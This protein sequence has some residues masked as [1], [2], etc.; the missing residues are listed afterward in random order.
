MP[1]N[2]APGVEVEETSFRP[3]P[4][5]G[6]STTTTGF[7]GPTRYGPIESQS[8][9][10]TSLSAFEAVYGNGL[11]LQY[12]GATVPHYLWHAARA[13]FENGGTRLYIARLFHPLIGTYPPSNWSTATQTTPGLYDDGHARLSIGSDDQPDN[14]LTLRARFPGAAGNLRVRL[15]VHRGPNLLSGTSSTPTLK[16]LSHHAVVWIG[17]TTDPHA[18]TPQPGTFYLAEFDGT[19]QTWRFKTGAATSETDLR[20]HHS[21]PQRSLNPILGTQVR[22]ISLTITVL[23]HASNTFVWKHLPLDPYHTRHSRPD[24]VLAVFTDIV[25]PSHAHSLPP[26]VITHGHD[27]PTGLDL[28]AVL[29]THKPLLTISLNKRKST[30]TARSV[31]LTLQ[32][33]NDGQ[34]PTT[35]DYRGSKDELKKTATGLQV[36]ETIEDISIVAAPGSTFGMEG[37]YRETALAISNVLVTHAERMHDRFAVLDSG[38]NQ[39][40]AQVRAIRTHLTSSYAALY[41]PWIRGLD[42]FTQTELLLPPSGFV[43]G[44]YVRTD[45]EHGVYRAPANQVVIGAVGFE[46]QLTQHEQEILNPEGI[47]CLRFFEGRGLRL[48]GARTVSTDPEWKYVNVRRYLIYLEQSIA[49][50]TQWVVFE[51]HS[52]LLWTTVRRMTEDFLHTEWRTGGLLGAKP[53]EAYFVKCDRSTMTQNDLDNGRLVCLIGVAL[54][55]PAEF[56]MFRIG[57]WTTTHH[58]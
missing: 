25:P 33:G 20:L 6:V 42:P 49:R 54:L 4:I 53:E 22:V 37:A 50:G 30:V 43:T 15:T 40:V 32:G 41:Y 10:L 36:F 7:V 28:L 57:Q 44:I 19:E 48:W 24:S 12:H 38:D 35:E 51:P 1:E 13:F 46:T 9:L 18:P 2:L 26:L 34:R 16:S 14:R 17:G 56:V 31:D 3:K 45:M 39:T 55:R 58:A 52:D 27:K 29:R 23:D 8:N 5:E 11:P 47:N 21:D